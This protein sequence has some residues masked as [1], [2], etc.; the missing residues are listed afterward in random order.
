[1]GSAKRLSEKAYVHLPKEIRQITDPIIRNRGRVQLTFEQRAERGKN[2]LKNR[3]KKSFKGRG[4][5]R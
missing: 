1:M 2:Y 5:K 3:I 4:K